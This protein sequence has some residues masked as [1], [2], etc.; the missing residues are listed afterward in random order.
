MYGVDVNSS[1]IS[2]FPVH[3]QFALCYYCDVPIDVLTFCP[4]HKDIFLKT[5]IT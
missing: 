4:V 3:A 2:E 1:E 5:Y